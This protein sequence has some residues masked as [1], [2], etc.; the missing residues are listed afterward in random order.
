[1][2]ASSRFGGTYTDFPPEGI[3]LWFTNNTI[4]LPSEHWQAQRRLASPEGEAASIRSM[5]YR[6]R[7]I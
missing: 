5:G 3:T 2:A 7:K 1:L 4:Y 6:F